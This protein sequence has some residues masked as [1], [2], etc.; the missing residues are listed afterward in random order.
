MPM[1]AREQVVL[2]EPI[3]SPDIG[4]YA[5]Q[6]ETAAGKEMNVPLVDMGTLIFFSGNL[7]VDLML[8][9]IFAIPEMIMI[10][11]G[12]F[13]AL[14]PI[15]AYLAVQLKVVI[16]AIIAIIYVILIIAFVADLRSRGG[17]T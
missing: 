15:N 5:E 3:H 14:F 4:D 7:V 6:V 1:E 17:V 13:L 11:I 10:L 9:T 12:G 2:F 8:N 16:F